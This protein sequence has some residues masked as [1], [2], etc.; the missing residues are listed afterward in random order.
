MPI[1]GGGKWKGIL[2]DPSDFKSET[3]LPLGSFEGIVSVV[4]LSEDETLIN[5]V[6]WI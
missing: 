6:I 5:N 2:L 3:G 4:F 1:A